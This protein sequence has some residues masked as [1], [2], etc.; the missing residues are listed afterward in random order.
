MCQRS[1]SIKGLHWRS[2]QDE[3]VAGGRLARHIQEVLGYLSQQRLLN[4]RDVPGIM[5][6]YQAIPQPVPRKAGMTS[7]AN[8]RMERSICPPVRVPKKKEP[9]K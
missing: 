6:F 1:K 8:R 3:S 9:T 4:L 5:T 2:W 7:W